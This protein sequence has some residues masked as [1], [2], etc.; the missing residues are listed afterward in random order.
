MTAQFK[1]IALPLLLATG[2]TAQTNTWDLG[3][4]DAKLLIGINLKNLRESELGQM[5]RAQMNARSAPMGPAGMAMGFLEQIDRVF[6]SSPALSSP[7]NS[8]PRLKTGAKAAPRQ[9]PPFLVI[10]EGA[11]P[12]QQLLAFLPGSSHPYHSVD[13]FQGVKP[14]DPSIAMLDTRTVVLGD[15]KS[16]LAAIDRRDHSAA[17][18]SATLA[19]ARQLASTH[20]FWMVVTDDLSKFQS[21]SA[22][23]PSQFTSEIKGIDMGMSA[24]DGFRFEMSMTM[25]TEGAAT[26]LVGMLTAQMAMAQMQNPDLAEAASKLQMGSQGNRLQASI[27]LSKD[28]FGQYIRKFQDARASA[29]AASPRPVPQSGPPPAQRTTNPPPPPPGKVRIYGL[30]EGVREIPLTR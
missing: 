4:P 26:Q 11:L 21:A 17:S 12:V 15:N 3:H 27:A 8:A 13:V 24:H 30:D 28:E 10:V 6:I 16:V 25:A 20:D 22:N 14:T 1:W 23:F 19:R 29:R 2:A 18:E 7:S 5:F 9:D